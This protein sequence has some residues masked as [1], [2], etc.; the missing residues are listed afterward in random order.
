MDFS[1]EP[2]K[3]VARF[4]SEI[5]TMLVLADTE[6]GVGSPTCQDFV[7]LEENGSVRYV[8]DRARDSLNT[9][10]LDGAILISQLL[11]DRALNETSISDPATLLTKAVQAR[12]EGEAQL[13]EVLFTQGMANYP[14]Y[15]D[16]YQGPAFRKELMR[17]FLARREWRRAIELIPPSG[18]PG[19]PYWYEILFA[20][21]YGQAGEIE[22]AAGFWEKIQQRDPRHQEASAF[23]TSIRIN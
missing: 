22:K 23:F 1:D 2:D 20:R 4:I 10:L 6:A 21:A 17:M 13:A 5:K 7:I 11:G 3:S 18:D 15:L 14:T 12:S 9:F 8:T 19:A 16:Q